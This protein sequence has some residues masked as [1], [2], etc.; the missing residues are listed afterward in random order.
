VLAV[1]TI[2]FINKISYIIIEYITN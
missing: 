1:A 2:N